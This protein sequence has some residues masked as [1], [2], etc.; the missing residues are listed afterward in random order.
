MNIQKDISLKAYNTFGIDV[1]ASH[2][3]SIKN[4]EELIKILQQIHCLYL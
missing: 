2:F 1:K 4:E 3:C